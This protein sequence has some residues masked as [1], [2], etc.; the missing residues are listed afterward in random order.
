MEATNPHRSLQK[1]PAATEAK[2][3]LQVLEKPKKSTVLEALTFEKGP[4]QSLIT[5]N[6]K[7][8]PL[9]PKKS[10]VDRSTEQSPKTRA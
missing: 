6:S 3:M 1:R 2:P 4:L 8:V 9:H 5:V 10:S 7:A